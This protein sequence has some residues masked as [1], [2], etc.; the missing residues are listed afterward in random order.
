LEFKERER[1]RERGRKRK[2]ERQ[3]LAK[4]TSDMESIKEKKRAIRI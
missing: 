1:E 4:I 3:L 2:R